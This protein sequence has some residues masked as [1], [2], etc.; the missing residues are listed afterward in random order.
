[1]A[2]HVIRAHRVCETCESDMSEELKERYA[3][4]HGKCCSCGNEGR[5][6]FIRTHEPLFCWAHCDNHS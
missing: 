4:H 3:Y 2:N 6:R 1:M 5:I